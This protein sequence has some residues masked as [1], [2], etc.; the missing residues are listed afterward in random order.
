MLAGRVGPDRAGLLVEAVEILELQERKFSRAKRKELAAKGMALPD[1][2]Y[3]IETKEDLHNA[4][5]LANS[6]HGNVAAAKRHIRKR[7]AAL[8]VKAKVAA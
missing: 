1:G 7:A 8:G 3:P 2:S 5:V 6:G 4:E